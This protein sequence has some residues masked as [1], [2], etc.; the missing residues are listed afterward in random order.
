LNEN[1]YRPGGIFRWLAIG[2]VILILV[3][4][5]ASIVSTVTHPMGMYPY[6][7]YHPF[8]FPFGI[9]FGIFMIFIVFGALKWIFRPWRW[10]RRRRY[11]RYRD[12]SYYILRERYAR[13]EITKEQYEQMMQDLQ[14][15]PHAVP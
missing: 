11:W 10:G 1:D 15:A 12:E 7:F 2:M 9:F 14:K 4:V 3:W 6:Q 5:A 8:F 13:G